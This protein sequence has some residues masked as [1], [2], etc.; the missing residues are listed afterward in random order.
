MKRKLNNGLFVWGIDDPNE[1]VVTRLIDEVEYI[2]RHEIYE[3]EIISL[4]DDDLAKVVAERVKCK[5][6]EC[7]DIFTCL[8]ELNLHSSKH[9]CIVIDCHDNKKTDMIEVLNMFGQFIYIYDNFYIPGDIIR[10]RIDEDHYETY[11]IMSAY[12][13]YDV[14]PYTEIV[15]VIN[16]NDWNSRIS[17]QSSQVSEYCYVGHEDLELV[18]NYFEKVKEKYNERI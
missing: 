14:D 17:I 6:I 5:L 3:T 10:Y 15:D 13:H 9:G 7:K 12:Y 11:M 16:V 1:E 2:K 18:N 8:A 4:K